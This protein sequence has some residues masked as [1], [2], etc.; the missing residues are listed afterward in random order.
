[1]VPRVR[2]SPRVCTSVRIGVTKLSYQSVPAVSGTK[3]AEM[4]TTLLFAG[5]ALLA[6]VTSPAASNPTF[7]ETGDC[8]VINV[9]PCKHRRCWCRQL[10]SPGYLRLH[11]PL[12]VDL[13]FLL[14]SFRQ[15]TH[16]NLYKYTA[17]EEYFGD[18]YA[19]TFGITMYFKV[20]CL[21]GMNLYVMQKMTVI[22]KC[23]NLQLERMETSERK[24]MS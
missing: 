23:T 15:A 20:Y 11:I 10:S 6:A 3:S 4:W 12:P 16:E 17:N 9:H 8:E 22:K 14:C 7:Q 5:A 24:S 21:S 2:S 1:M 18:E 19:Q 13:S